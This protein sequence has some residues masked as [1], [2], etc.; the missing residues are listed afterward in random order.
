MLDAVRSFI[1]EDITAC[2][3]IQRGLASPTYDVGPLA[4]THEAPIT[5]FHEHV[6][7]A[8]R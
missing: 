4:L 7:A 8:L 3:R 6:L 5:R 2:E 1:D